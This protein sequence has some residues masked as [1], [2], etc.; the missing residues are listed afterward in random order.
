MKT[1]KAIL[2][3]VIAVLVLALLVTA[4]DKPW[5]DMEKC[6]FCSQIMAQP[7]LMDHITKWE[8]HNT[9]NGSMSITVVDPEYVGA[10][11]EAMAKMQ[12]VGQKMQKGEPTYMCGMCEAYG[13]IMMKGAQYDV[14]ESDN[15]FVVN[16]YSDNPDLVNDIHAM[17]DRTN[18]EMK[19][20]TETEKGEKT[21]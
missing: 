11:K 13:A 1:A 17:T 5:F 19:K 15:I 16:M 10:Y 8:H 6:A 20:M 3:V 7:G 9:K 12:E 2:M 4:E 21:D 14:V 18:E